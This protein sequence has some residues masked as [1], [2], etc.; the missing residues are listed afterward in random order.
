MNSTGLCAGSSSKDAH[1]MSEKSQ[2]SLPCLKFNWTY[3]VLTI[4]VF[5]RHIQS[6]ET[7]VLLILDAHIAR[8]HTIENAFY[9]L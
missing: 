8:V 6:T 7:N 2:V 9:G 1:K 5:Y 4:K 3:C